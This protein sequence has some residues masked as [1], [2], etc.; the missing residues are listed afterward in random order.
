MSGIIFG[1]MLQVIVFTTAGLYPYAHYS[2]GV[3]PGISTS[4]LDR[5]LRVDNL[6]FPRTARLLDPFHLPTGY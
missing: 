2:L 3:S 5:T 6:A 1:V 4:L